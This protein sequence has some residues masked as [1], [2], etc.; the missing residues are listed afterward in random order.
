MGKT[1]LELILFGVLLQRPQTGYDLSSFMEKAG[2][3]LRTNTSM[4]QVYRSLRKMEELGWVSHTVE[5]RPGAQ[6]AKR[7]AVTDEGRTEFLNWLREPYH[8]VSMPAAPD[9][10]VHLRFRASY[11]GFDAALEVLDAEIAYRRQQILRNR[12]RDRTE[13]ID[14]SIPFNEDLANTIMDWE[15]H[16]GVDRMDRHLEACLELRDRLAAGETS[17]DDCPRLLR[18]VGEPEEHEALVEESAG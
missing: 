11:L 3:F 9:F 16:R 4:T 5:P 13:W 6:D 14:P 15:H 1:K 2:R 10:F 12:H 17:N 7:Y 18:H 8:P